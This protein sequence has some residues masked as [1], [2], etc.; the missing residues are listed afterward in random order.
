MSNSTVADK[1]KLFELLTKVLDKGKKDKHFELVKMQEEALELWS[2]MIMEEHDKD[3][4]SELNV[5]QIQKSCNAWLEELLVLLSNG[6]VALWTSEGTIKK[7]NCQ[8]LIHTVLPS[9]AED[10]D[11]LRSKLAVALETVSVKDSENAGKDAEINELK[12]RL[13]EK[14][15]R[16]NDG[17]FDYNQ[18]MAHEFQA[19]KSILTSLQTEL[20]HATSA[21]EKGKNQ[22]KVHQM[23]MVDLKQK[24]SELDR[25]VFAKNGNVAELSKQIADLDQEKALSH[26]EIARLQD[27][28]IACRKLVMLTRRRIEEHV[29]PEHDILTHL[30]KEPTTVA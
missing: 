3:M 27:C 24:V 13:Q 6:D 28:C 4:K 20:F 8:Q 29:L 18:T 15:R 11:E 23:E 26:K 25:E 19:L 2:R 12:L 9:D 21:L 10:I 22:E 16:F 30:E 7:A 17:S 14:A 5:S 1:R